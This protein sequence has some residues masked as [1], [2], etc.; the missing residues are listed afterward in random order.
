MK[1][2]PRI[3]V[4][5]D[6]NEGDFIH[7]INSS[8]SNRMLLFK[9]K[10]SDP[11]IVDFHPK[12]GYVEA[13][14]TLKVAIKLNGS[15]ISSARILVQLVA[16][17]RKSY[18]S[19]FDN[20]WN[21]GI[22]K[23]MVKKV[24]DIRKKGAS[25]DNEM[26]S[27]ASL[28]SI[29]SQD[30]CT[31]GESK[32]NVQL[33]GDLESFNRSN[34][35]SCMNTPEKNVNSIMRYNV[36]ADSTDNTEK[37]D[38]CA[39]INKI[40]ESPSESVIKNT[41][42]NIPLSASNN[43]S[44]SKIIGVG[45]GIN[46]YH[47]I[48]EIKDIETTEVLTPLKSSVIK[49]GKSINTN[50]TSESQKDSEDLHRNL[51][52]NDHADY[53]LLAHLEHLENERKKASTSQSNDIKD[54]QLISKCSCIRNLELSEYSNIDG[55]NETYIL[56]QGDSVV[57]ING[58][59]AREDVVTKSLEIHIENLVAL[60]RRTLSIEI[61]D[62]PIDRYVIHISIFLAMYDT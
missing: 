34:Q 47:S 2:Y 22:K 4:I 57:R 26:S 61:F 42:S 62:S 25:F 8:T 21:T 41:V 6:D 13:G 5:S 7:V 39:I 55:V 31:G 51:R 48:L 15:N 53:V 11:K 40:V 30:P 59:I 17:I 18:T 37:N 23:G 58:A 33:L 43:G 49:S 45:L 46:K 27:N 19:E 16:V 35:N 28:I 54:D 3:L 52:Y 14:G 36:R 1:V 10:R 29:L 50:E 24:V 60:R 20:D 12:K 32:R 9:I 44:T 38:K 56:E